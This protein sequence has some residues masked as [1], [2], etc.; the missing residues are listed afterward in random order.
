MLVVSAC[1]GRA[2][3]CEGDF[4]YASVMFALGVDEAPPVDCFWAVA[5]AASVEEESR[6]RF[7]GEEGYLGRVY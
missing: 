4:A 1:D 6:L 5:E 3:L 7:A 2:R